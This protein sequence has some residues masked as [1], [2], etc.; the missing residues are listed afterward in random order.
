[1]GSLAR[2][3]CV[4]AA[5]M[6]IML[7][8]ACASTNVTVSPSPQTPV[9]NGSASALVLWTSRWRPNQKDVSAREEAAA[10]GLDH[11]FASSGCFARAELRRVSS[12]SPSAVDA[13][14][15]ASGDRFNAVVSIA[16]HELGPVVKLLSSASLVEG[17]TEVVLQVTSRQLQPSGPPREFKVHWRHGGPGVVKGVNS[18]P[19]DMNAALR[20]GLQPA[21]GPQ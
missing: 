16:V 15:A 8:A 10:S 18:L 21:S 19:S 9:C 7:L 3:V 1:M 11:F 5:G 4:I 6:S 12:L 17:G 20:A 2:T 14:L 13:E